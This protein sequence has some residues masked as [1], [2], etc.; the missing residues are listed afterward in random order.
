[1][2]LDRFLHLLRQYKFQ[3]R[4]KQKV[5]KQYLETRFTNQMDKEAMLIDKVDRNNK[6]ALTT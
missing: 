2:K 4:R 5:R 6:C 3:V 1:M